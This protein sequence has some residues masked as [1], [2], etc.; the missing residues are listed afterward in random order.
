MAAE[1]EAATAEEAWAALSR[2]PKRMAEVDAAAVSTMGRVVA[3]V[4]AA[5]D[6]GAAAAG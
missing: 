3:A 6:D 4:A 2:P 5:A 1:A